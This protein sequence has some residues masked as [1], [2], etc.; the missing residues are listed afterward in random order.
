MPCR[1]LLDPLLELLHDR[2]V[3]KVLHAGQQDL[4]LMYSLSGKIAAPV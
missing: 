1:R 3:E 4:E 2:K